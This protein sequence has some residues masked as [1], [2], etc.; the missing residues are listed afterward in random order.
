MN[1]NRVQINFF[2]IK[3]NSIIISFI[4]ILITISSS[5]VYATD[6]SYF[7][8][9]GSSSKSHKIKM[10]TN[11]N[12]ANRTAL[13]Y[14]F[15]K[16]DSPLISDDTSTS[17]K[18]SHKYKL[19]SKS[20]VS[21]DFKLNDEIYFFTS[22]SI[23]GYFQY[24]MAENKDDADDSLLKYFIQFGYHQ[25]ES[26]YLNLPQEQLLIHEFDI[27]YNHD[28][29]SHIS[30]GFEFNKYN[31]QTTSQN[32]S[33]ALQTIP[34]IYSDISNYIELLTQHSTSIF[35]DLTYDQFAMGS[36]ITIEDSLIGSS[37]MQSTDIYFDWNTNSNL[38]LSVGLTQTKSNTS[39][40]KNNSITFGILYEL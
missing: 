28:F 32:I 37:Q 14:K 4:Y 36:S 6:F 40:T 13:F 15:T 1:Q 12:N 26:K 7:Y 27:S 24:L 5:L 29:N 22:K 8:T 16:D 17:F 10:A 34:I 35:I 11:V 19:P 25:T 31:Y 39:T 18:I 23:G 3:L 30:A 33:A 9:R 20:S 2:N 38:T 21:I